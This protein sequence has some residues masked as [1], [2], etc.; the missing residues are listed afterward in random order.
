MF[1]ARINGLN[2]KRNVKGVPQKL[3]FLMP[4]KNPFHCGVQGVGILQDGKI[5]GLVESK[6][7]F[8]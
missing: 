4:L 1:L 7:I 6:N 3:V 5:E 8:F 2:I